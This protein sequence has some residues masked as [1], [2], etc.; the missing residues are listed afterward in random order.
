M[1]SMVKNFLRGASAS[2]YLMT[3]GASSVTYIEGR[4]GLE[5]G[6]GPPEVAT[7]PVPRFDDVC[8]SLKEWPFAGF[9]GE[10]VAEAEAKLGRGGVCPRASSASVVM[11]FAPEGW[12][13]PLS[14]YMYRQGMADSMRVQWRMR[15]HVSKS[16]TRPRS[17]C[18]CTPVAL[19]GVGTHIECDCPQWPS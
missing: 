16:L 2:L 7:E 10:Q 18:H 13:A 17:C 19:P 6:G 4:I 14:Y 15:N 1:L 8:H 3:L 9:T 11:E 12:F 5:R